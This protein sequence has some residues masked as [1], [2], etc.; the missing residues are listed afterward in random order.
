[1]GGSISDASF[2]TIIL[3]SLPASW[4]AIVA[5]LYTTTSSVDALIQLDAHWSRISSH[6]RKRLNS[7]TSPTALQ[8]STSRRIVYENKNC[9]RPGHSIEDCYWVGGG[10]QGQFPLGFGKCWQQQQ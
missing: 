1:M 2:H 7:S 4:D 9:Q 3:G 8:A 5:T 10:K 6:D